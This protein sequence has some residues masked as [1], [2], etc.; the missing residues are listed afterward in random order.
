M[1]EQNRFLFLVIINVILL[2]ST[3][4]VFPQPTTTATATAAANSS[5][6]LPILQ[7]SDNFTVF[8]ATTG[9]Q[10]PQPSPTSYSPIDLYEE[11]LT[12]N[13]PRLPDQ[14]PLSYIYNNSAIR[15]TLD[16]GVS[17]GLKFSTEHRLQPAESHPDFGKEVLKCAYWLQSEVTNLTSVRFPGHDAQSIPVQRVMFNSVAF[18][19]SSDRT[20]LNLTFMRS[21]DFD[22]AET[23][24]F[25]LNF[26]GLCLDSATVFTQRDISRSLFDVDFVVHPMA[27]RK[28]LVMGKG[29]DMTS[30]DVAT[31]AAYYEALI[32]GDRFFV[33]D[34]AA[35]TN[36]NSTELCPPTLFS[37]F[38]CASVNVSYGGRFLRV[39]LRSNLSFYVTAPT[40][41]LIPLHAR[42]FAEGNSS[43]PLYQPSHDQ[44]VLFLPLFIRL[45]PGTIY[46]TVLRS[47]VTEE[48]IRSGQLDG[49]AVGVPI[50]FITF[51]LTGDGFKNDTAQLASF[52][53]RTILSNSTFCSWVTYNPYKTVRQIEGSTVD[54]FGFC[55]KMKSSLLKTAQ[56]S[57]KNQVLRIYL[58]G[59]DDF[60]VFLE[61]F[62]DVSFPV[63]NWLVA[64]EFRNETTGNVIN[65]TYRLAPETSL[66]NT[67]FASGFLPEVVRSAG[68]VVAPVRGTYS[69]TEG[70]TQ[71][72]ERELNDPANFPRSA[73][74]LFRLKITLKNERFITPSSPY[75]KAASSS[76]SSSSSSSS[77]FSSTAATSPLQSTIEN[78]ISAGLVSYQK[79]SWEL[80]GWTRYGKQI[81]LSSAA[82]SWSI[83]TTNYRELQVTLGYATDFR[84]A[85]NETILITVPLSSVMSPTLEPRFS[86]ETS[87]APFSS[88]SSF[89]VAPNFTISAS[90]GTIELFPK[91]IKASWL[92][93]LPK[94]VSQ[95]LPASFVVNARRV[96][97]LVALSGDGFDRG[98]LG[99]FWDSIVAVVDGGG[100]GEGAVASFLSSSRP[101]LQEPRGFESQ[102]PFLLDFTRRHGIG[103]IMTLTKEKMMNCFKTKNNNINNNNNKEEDPRSIL[104]S[105]ILSSSAYSSASPTVSCFKTKNQ[106]SSSN[107]DFC[108]FAEIS[109]DPVPNYET[110]TTSSIGEII[111]LSVSG[112]WTT[113]GVTPAPKSPTQKSNQFAIVPS[114]ET[115]N[116]VVVSPKSSPSSAASTA[117]TWP[118]LQSDLANLLSLLGADKDRIQLSTSTLVT[119][120]TTAS[121]SSQSLWKKVA[122]MENLFSSDALDTLYFVSF[123]IALPSSQ[124]IY[125]AT[126]SSSSGF[127]DPQN[128]ILFDNDAA[129][130]FVQKYSLTKEL[131]DAT[132]IAACWI[133][134]AT[135]SGFDDVVES[136][137]ES[138]VTYSSTS[139]S[140]PSSSST[141]TTAAAAAIDSFWSSVDREI[142]FPLAYDSP[143]WKRLADVIELAFF[144]SRTTDSSSS[145]TRTS[146]SAAVLAQ[147][148]AA[149]R[150]NWLL[151]PIV[152]NPDEQRKLEA[153]AAKRDAED[154]DKVRIELYVFIPIISL[155]LLFLTFFLLEQKFGYCAAMQ[156][157][158]RIEKEER[159]ERDQQQ[160]QTE[161]EMESLRKKSPQKQV[162]PS[163][164]KNSSPFLSTANK[165][166][167][168]KEHH[169]PNRKSSPK[170]SATS[171]VSPFAEFVN[172]GGDRDRDH[173]DS[174]GAGRGRSRGRG[175]RSIAA[176]SPAPRILPSEISL[177]EVNSSFNPTSMNEFFDELGIGGVTVS[178]SEHHEHRER[179]LEYEHERTEEQHSSKVSEI[180]VASENPFV[181]LFLVPSAA[182]ESRQQ[183]FL[184]D[185]IDDEAVFVSPRTT[186]EILH[187]HHRSDF[188]LDERQRQ[189][190]PRQ[191]QRPRDRTDDADDDFFFFYSPSDANDSQKADGVFDV[192]VED[193]IN[194]MFGSGNTNKRKNEGR[195]T[196]PI[197][198]KPRQHHQDQFQIVLDDLQWQKPQQFSNVAAV[199]RDP[200][201]DDDIF[202]NQNTNNSTL[203]HQRNEVEIEPIAAHAPPP[204]QQHQQQRQ[205]LQSTRKKV[206]PFMLQDRKPATSLS[207]PNKS[208]PQETFFAPKKA[209]L[210]SRNQRSYDD[211]DEQEEVDYRNI[212]NDVNSANYYSH[213]TSATHAEK[214]GAGRD[215]RGKSNSSNQLSLTSASSFASDTFSPTDRRKLRGKVSDNAQNPLLSPV[216]TTRK[217]LPLPASSPPPSGSSMISY[218]SPQQL[219]QRAVEVANGTKPKSDVDALTALFMDI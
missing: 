151:L 132:G 214:F 203:E 134:G 99:N 155:L 59:D 137:L 190:Q 21:F 210:R 66:L 182:A 70:F 104:L 211:D 27:R 7:R 34:S 118:K 98:N 183:H 89:L 170:A 9:K 10:I 111:S 181:K 19:F 95:H 49:T 135:E 88:T 50:A 94:T 47:R 39:V 127:Y 97:I 219:Q 187:Q 61:E 12:T 207:S 147:V 180:D 33:G 112:G 188:D 125:S 116:A 22:I 142:L 218:G 54:P 164:Y 90:P 108:D 24:S 179:E 158:R 77:S 178:N 64:S 185:V 79:S 193:M 160:Q 217:K 85:S 150:M 96:S 119:T 156:E 72:S 2:L 15:L 215:D 195:S 91:V 143:A 140:S 42:Y 45:A 58:T 67:S 128:G 41:V 68:F 173:D 18:V 138:L 82:G 148:S 17:S 144:R 114:F 163:I 26:G 14:T 161:T 103:D 117:P 4:H 46:T 56:I 189:E 80:F 139:S 168:S 36:L 5:S 130:S 162:P 196:K 153:D 1:S 145:V 11:D 92:N 13:Y 69:I 131:F 201:F 191:E 129:R 43:S 176:A 38:G 20:K 84:V 76:F 206:N 208:L 165:K 202:N 152:V 146:T 209:E 48:E 120:A 200:F 105:S 175:G 113:S 102:K 44:S 65:V 174:D 71:V 110:T 40:T 192:D 73:N 167:S 28:V 133:R 63:P 109:L 172:G 154:M 199:Y 122:P 126:A 55:G 157:K 204:P 124:Q 78:F 6:S 29:R 8:N 205:Q 62:V 16:L 169:P 216:I 86:A 32:I 3:C 75:Y 177:F 194:G 141:T 52:L 121:N 184:H 101:E 123:R 87:A 23:Y 25:R 30:L 197:E 171:Y 136:A 115:I 186:N 212:Y 100:G 93:S 83:S 60:D 37:Q 106:F 159:E 51:T 81:I 198:L 57:S 166:S 149:A 213:P 31:G 107:Q 74:K 35:A 53:L